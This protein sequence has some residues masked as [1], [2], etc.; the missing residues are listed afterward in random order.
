MQVVSREKS[1]GSA[2]KSTSQIPSA[3]ANSTTLRLSV[4]VRADRTGVLSSAGVGKEAPPR[5][6]VEAFSAATRSL[7]VGIV[8]DK[9]VGEL[10]LHKVHLG[11]QK[12]QLSLLLYKHPHACETLQGTAVTHQGLSLRLLKT[13]NRDSERIIKAANRSKGL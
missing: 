3:R 10:R 12:G 9:L 5:S 4:F 11:S 8:E 6:H 1:D 2:R 13:E 7:D